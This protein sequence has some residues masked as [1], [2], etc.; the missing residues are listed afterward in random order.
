MSMFNGL[1]ESPPGAAAAAAPGHQAD[2]GAPLHV[3]AYGLEAGELHTLGAILHVLKTRTEAAWELGDLDRADF[4]IAPLALARDPDHGLPLR[5]RNVIPLVA[6]DGPLPREGDLVLTSPIR[7]MAVLEVLNL[8]S[9]RLGQVPQAPP[10]VPARADES[11]HA[12]SS[13]G[14]VLSASLA[15]TRDDHALRIR[16]L[17]AGTIY[18]WP[19]ERRFHVD[20][21]LSMLPRI[22]MERRFVMTTAPVRAPELAEIRPQAMPLTPLLWSIGIAQTRC[23]DPSATDAYRLL[24]WP[25]FD[26]LPH[27]MG[28]LRLC[29]VMAGTAW[30]VEDLQRHSGL[31]APF[32]ARFLRACVACGYATTEPRAA[33]T[34]PAAVRT[35]HAS[36]N[37][38]GGLLERLWRRLGF[39]AAA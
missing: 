22:V 31:P 21:P 39:G 4:V 11:A 16:I 36:A 24:R 32:V 20:F 33:E 30:T 38:E 7:V 3:A 9:R 25:E 18:V 2:G 1:I 28:H 29:G 34:P 17:S 27:E 13:L 5:G 37:A 12:D 23:T 6:E 14:A 10:E 19:S 8:A 35:P 15:R 26:R